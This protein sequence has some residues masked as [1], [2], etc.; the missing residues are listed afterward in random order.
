MSQSFAP[1]PGQGSENAYPAMAGYL[2]ATMGARFLARLLDG[3]LAFLVLVILYYLLLRGWNQ[4]HSGIPILY[5]LVV[6]GYSVFSLAILLISGATIGN[7]LM[8][9]RH[10]AVAT[11]RIAR[12]ATFFKYFLEGLVGA[13]TLGIG[14]LA[15]LMTIR[16]PFNQHWADRAAGVAVVDVKRGRDPRRVGVAAAPAQPPIAQPAAPRG[17]LTPVASPDQPPVIGS[18]PGFGGWTPS[19]PPAVDHWSHRPSPVVKDM[20]S[21]DA[22]TTM[23]PPSDDGDNLATTIR[24]GSGTSTGIVLDNGE[25]L[26]V[27]G[28]LLLGRNPA[29][30][31]GFSDARLVSVADQERSI[32]KTHL[33]VGPAGAGVW[34]QDLHSTNG[35]SVCDSSG[36]TLRATPGER[37]TVLPGST[38]TYG[39]R[40]FVVA[41]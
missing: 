6:V 12:G 20:R 25:R 27:D 14:N 30:Y 1:G 5:L 41:G 35:V 19:S 2:P 17:G 3:L 23:P 37:I 4:S 11:G 36:V 15:L 21:V 29:P 16:A 28:I 8:G 13:V 31:P 9:Q 18:V 24:R 10:V 32:S 34:I 38:V 39:E 33:A 40:S 22:H 26:S 7:L